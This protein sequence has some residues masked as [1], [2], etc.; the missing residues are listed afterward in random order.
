M[1]P[2]DLF[3]N[4][5][6]RLKI[7]TVGTGLGEGDL[8]PPLSH[9]LHLFPGDSGTGREQVGTGRNKLGQA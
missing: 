9:L 4:Y 6:F 2:L 3:P 7:K 8:N 5:L 1:N